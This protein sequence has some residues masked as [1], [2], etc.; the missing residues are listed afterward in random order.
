MR[1]IILH[2]WAYQTDR[3]QAL[4]QTLQAQGL[5]PEFPHIPVLTEQTDHAWTVNDYMTWLERL[6]GK[7][8]VILVGHSNG[9][10]LSLNFAGRHPGQ[11]ERL[12]L[13]DSAGIPR[14]ELAARIKRGIFWTLAKLGKPLAQVMFLRRLL[15]KMARA[16]DYLEADPI[17][18]ETMTNLLKSDYAL[19][20]SAVTVPTTIIWG[21]DDGMTPLKD[22]Y[23]LAKQL[24]HAQPP[25][26]ISNARHSPQF[27]HTDQVAKIIVRA[28]RV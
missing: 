20:L 9:G 12:I 21:K 11:I 4:L 8:K 15:Y 17:S 28:V 5:E 24:P 14:T 18:R 7:D 26:V 27:T 6:I 22:A 2:G 10:R 3:W 19:N 1:L 16:K 25:V 23:T 13:I